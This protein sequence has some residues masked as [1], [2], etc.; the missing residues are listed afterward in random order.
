MMRILCKV[1]DLKM[2]VSSRLPSWSDLADW[3]RPERYFKNKI[4]DARRSQKLPGPT[5][6]KKPARAS[7]VNWFQPHL[8]AIISSEARFVP[9]MSPT[10]LRD[11]LRS[12]HPILFGHISSQ[13][14]G[15]M[16]ETT[17]SGQRVW[18]ADTLKRVGLQNGHDSRS[19][20][21][22]TLVC[23]VTISLVFFLS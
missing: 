9:G 22:G 18:S 13:V 14:L 23:V 4:N 5:A 20:Q 10:E 17:D 7:Q 21:H 8:W 19:T 1:V 11:R 3:S 15:R 16:I 2:D 12:K 6:I